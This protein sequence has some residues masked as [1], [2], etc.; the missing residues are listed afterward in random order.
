MTVGSPGGIHFAGFRAVRP[1]AIS[2]MDGSR[3]VG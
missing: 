1:R 2:V 3:A